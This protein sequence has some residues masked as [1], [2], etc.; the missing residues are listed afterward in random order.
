MGQLY[1]SGFTIIE[2]MLFLAITGVLIATILVG[3]GASLNI[4][5]YRD[6]VSSLKSLIQQ[7]YSEA[8]N[9]QN[10]VRTADISCDSNAVVAD[11]GNLKPRGQSDCV[12]MGRYILLDQGNVTTDTVVGHNTGSIIG[13]GDIDIIK[14]YNLALL[15]S[16]AET[17][18][19][20]W[21]TA[22][23]WPISGGGSKSP[24]TPR[25]L[26]I[27]I[28]RSPSSGQ[29]YTFSADGALTALKDMVVSGSTVPGQ[30]NR[31]ICVDSKGLFSGGGTAIHINEYASS[32]NDIE[33]WS[34]AINKANQCG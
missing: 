28:I 12:V 22:I 18:P 23:A 10:G 3:T 21:G 15:N 27:L 11:S 25:T 33:T 9:V 32:A 29:T 26:A 20:E 8:I 17:A 7:Q 19:L 6:S 16:S 1:K 2:T 34:N 30:S 4:Q 31:T 14:S 5:R 13:L 24:T